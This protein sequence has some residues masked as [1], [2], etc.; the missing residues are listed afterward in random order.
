[1]FHYDFF[2]QNWLLQNMAVSM[3]GATLQLVY[4]EAYTLRCL[5]MLRYVLPYTPVVATGVCVE[6]T[7]VYA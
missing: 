6:N 4:A 7:H 5:C 3:G 2:F 1:M